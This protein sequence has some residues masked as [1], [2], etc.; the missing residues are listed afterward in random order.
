MPNSAYKHPVQWEFS[1]CTAHRQPFYPAELRIS[2]CADLHRTNAYSPASSHE[3]LPLRHLSGNHARNSIKNVSPVEIVDSH[4]KRLEALHPK[5]NTFVHLNARAPAAV[6]LAEI[7]VC[8]ARTS[9]LSMAF[10]LLS[11][12]H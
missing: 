2:P 12:L 10:R 4:L 1:R 7:C 3:L 5:L 9:E 8:A 6:A 11:R